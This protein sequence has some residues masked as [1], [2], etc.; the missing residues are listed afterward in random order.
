MSYIACRVPSKGALPPNSPHRAPIERE[1]HSIYRALFYCFSKSLVNEHTFRFSNGA[2]IERGAHFQ[3]LPFTYSSG[4]P[5][6]EVFVLELL[7][8][9]HSIMESFDLGKE[10]SSLKFFVWHNNWGDFCVCVWVWLKELELSC[11]N[12]VGVTEDRKFLRGPDLFSY[13]LQAKWTIY[14]FMAS[15]NILYQR[16]F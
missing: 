14:C 2:P 4:S 15:E 8:I 7:F 3:G 12:L 16:S 9:V 6:K 13:R 1:R 11:M 10:L 5:V